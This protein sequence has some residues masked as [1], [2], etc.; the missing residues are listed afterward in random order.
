MD[1]HKDSVQVC[2]LDQAGHVLANQVVDN[3]R[4][5]IAAVAARC[6]RVRRAALEVGSGAADLAEELVDREGWLT[7]LAHPGYV[8]R[9][10][11]SPDKT[12]F[13]DARLLADLTRVG[14]LPR[15]WLAPA[16]IRELRRLVR[17]RQQQV[18]VRRGTKLRIRA[19]LRDHRIP[20]PPGVGAWT[21]RWW[22]WLMG[23]VRPALPAGSAFILERHVARLS[24]I[25]EE[26]AQTHDYLRRFTGEDPVIARLR[27]LAGV[28]EVTAWV[29]RAEIGCF[30]RF[31]RSKSLARFCG[32]SPRNASSGARQA[33]AGLI[34]AGSPL[35]RATLI[36]L[37]HRLCRWDVYWHDFKQQLVARGK[38]GSVATAAVANRWV[39]RLFHV[40]GKQESTK[41]DLVAKAAVSSSPGWA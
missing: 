19:L 16:R 33:D 11:G 10:K 26:L 9:M 37:A 29:L 8:A 36:E 15:V 24:R 27:S 31:D 4:R 21:N 25:A 13:A 40:M 18:E 35:L 5:A 6:G 30:E 39:R 7:E 23:V 32:L 2:V 38:P 41:T 14:Y 20:G 28:G 17:Y 3:D 34:R 1:Y 22:G 12:D